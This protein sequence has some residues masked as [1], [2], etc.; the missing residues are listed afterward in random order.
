MATDVQIKPEEAL[1]GMERRRYPRIPLKL[2]FLGNFA[3][4]QTSCEAADQLLVFRSINLSAG[5]ILME[6]KEPSPIP[7]RVRLVLR[8]FSDIREPLSIDAET[9]RFHDLKDGY[10]Y[11]GVDFGTLD[12]QHRN[13]IENFVNL[14]RTR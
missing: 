13:K 10:Y 11:Y 4:K 12:E 3:D 7:G 6:A 8:Y 5:G 14:V 9:V 1:T 2:I